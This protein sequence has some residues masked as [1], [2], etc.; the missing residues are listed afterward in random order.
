[1]LGEPSP[2]QDEYLAIRLSQDELPAIGYPDIREELRALGASIAGATVWVP[3]R[4]EARAREILARALEDEQPVDADEEPRAARKS[5]RGRREGKV[6]V[7]EANKAAAI[8]LGDPHA[9]DA[10]DDGGAY[11]VHKLY[12]EDREPFPLLLSRPMVGHLITAIREGW[13]L[14][15]ASRGQLRIPDEFRTNTGMFRIPR[16]KPV[17]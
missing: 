2:S 3:R 7:I 5:N 14:W 17:L 1:M 8:Y 12:N 13:L 11:A 9:F 6:S 15:D 10:R 4:R 16:G